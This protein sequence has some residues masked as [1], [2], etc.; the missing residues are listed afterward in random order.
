MKRGFHY[1]LTNYSFQCTGCDAGTGGTSTPVPGLS[2]P[3]NA[4]NGVNMFLGCFLF[5]NTKPTVLPKY[6]Q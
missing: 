3:T 2:C 5:P 6:T 1:F 4:N